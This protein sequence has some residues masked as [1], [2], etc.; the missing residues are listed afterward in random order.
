MDKKT[1]GV[2]VAVVLVVVSVFVGLSSYLPTLDQNNKIIALLTSFFTTG[3]VMTAV[4]L[5]RNIIGF[6]ME[7]AKSG[8]TETFEDQKLYQTMAYYIGIVAFIGSIIPEPYNVW[9]VVI[10]TVA[11]L[12]LQA[13]K[14][15][16]GK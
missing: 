1:L 4:A 13:T 2:I 7:Y 14:T 10:M 8:F 16:W 3:T 6:A 5:I 9:G 11:D 12:A 15:L